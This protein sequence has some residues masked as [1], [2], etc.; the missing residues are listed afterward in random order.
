MARENPIRGY[1]RIQVSS[2]DS[3]TECIASRWP[4]AGPTRRLGMVGEVCRGR[5][6]HP[7]L[8]RRDAWADHAGRAD[9]R[10]ASSRL[11]TCPANG[12]PSRCGCGAATRRRRRRPGLV[13]AT[14]RQ[15]SVLDNEE[16]TKVSRRLDHRQADERYRSFVHELTLSPQRSALLARLRDGHEPDI[17][18]WCSHSGHAH[19]WE[20][21]PCSTLRL[22]DHVDRGDC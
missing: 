9:R 4:D 21:H 13:V 14:F 3:A 17:H 16:V 22:A 19:H 6:L 18:D 1:R 15:V 10:A 8:E 20:R 7:E 2:S 5:G 12:R 11:I